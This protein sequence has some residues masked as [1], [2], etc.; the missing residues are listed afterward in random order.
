MMLRNI[1]AK[2]TVYSLFARLIG[3]TSGRKQ[4]VKRHIRPRVG[5][6]LLD[7]GCGPAD[8]LEA[9]P[10]VDYH[11]FDLSPQYIESARVRFGTRGRF[12]VQAVN[13]ALLEKYQQASISSWRRECCTT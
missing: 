2:P 8:I 10:E 7:I 9:L 5:D 4:Y 11:G 13:L 1:L 6:R 3:A 12:N